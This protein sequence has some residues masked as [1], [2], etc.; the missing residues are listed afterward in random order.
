MTENTKKFIKFLSKFN[1]YIKDKNI[2][3]NSLIH[4]TY[5][6]EQKLINNNQKLEF[7]GDSILGLVI[8]EYIFF[9]YK[10]KNEGELSKIK[11]FIVSKT[12]LVKVAK[13]IKLYDY[14]LVGKSEKK[15][16]GKYKASIMADAMESVFAAIYLDK[17]YK[18]V[19]KFIIK[20]FSSIFNDI[21]NEGINDYKTIL[22][23]LVQK[24]YKKNI[25]YKILEKK[26]P[27]HNKIFKSGIYWNNKI[28]S[29]G[30]GKNKKKSEIKAAKNAIKYF[31]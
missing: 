5:S 7:L 30:T 8:A 4:P 16:G 25:K 2:I 9:K 3:E 10:N 21:L 14:L 28:I 23:E 22:Q 31:E 26:G 24:K 27:D 13:K 6:Y 20:L 18:I 17:G 29:T 15:T 12:S 19:K 1:I 11:N